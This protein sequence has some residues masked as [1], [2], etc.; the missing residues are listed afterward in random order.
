MSH[1]DLAQT[2]DAAFEAR[3]DIGFNTTGE[4]RD[5]VEQALALLDSGEARVAQKIDGTCKSISGSK[6][7]CCS[8]S[9]ST[10]TA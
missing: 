4:V 9:G 2:I 3:A 10:T 8:I 6:R 1:T 5:A 7:R